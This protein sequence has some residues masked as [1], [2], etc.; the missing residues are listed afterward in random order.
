[1][2]ILTLCD[3]SSNRPETLASRICTWWVACLHGVKYFTHECDRSVI[4]RLGRIHRHTAPLELLRNCVPPSTAGIQHHWNYSGTVFLRPQP[5][6]STIGTTP[7]LCSSVDSRHTAPLELLR[8]C[9]PPSTAG[10]QH[11]WNYSGTVF[12]RPQ[13]AYSTIGTTPELCSSVHSRHTAPLKLLRN[14]VPP[15]T[16]GI[17]HHWNYS[18]TVFLRPQLAYSTIGTTPELC[19]SVH[20]RHT[21]PLEL[22]RNCV[23]PSTAGIQH[24]WNYSGTVFLRPQPAYSTIGT[25]PE[26]C[27]S[28]HSRHTAPLE[29][30]R[31]CV[32]PSTAGIQHHC[33]Y[34]GTVFLRPQPAYS[35]IGTTPELCSSVH[36][37]HTAPLELLRNCVPPSA[38]GIQHHWNYSGTVF[39]RPQPAYSTIGTTPEL[40]S[41]I[42]NRH[43]APLELLRNCVPPSTAGIQHHWNYSGTVFL[44]PQPAYST[45][46][47][48]PELCSSVHSRHTAPLELL[49]NC[50]PPSA[51]GIQHHWNYSGTVFLRPQPAYSTIGTT[52]ELCS[53]VHSRHAAPLELLRNCVPLSTTGSQ[54]RRRPI[55]LHTHMKIVTGRDYVVI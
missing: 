4:L 15:S 16:A 21:A 23:P 44:H 5:A 48:T 34:S 55:G 38:T 20:S 8:N 1:M 11:H 3:I 37:R 51:T 54:Q 50:V 43:T 14:C 52:P 9:V 41:S 40:C 17:Q 7:E 31:N 47:T 42:H 24:H 19:S 53:S 28:V 25:T 12:L 26:L 45:I 39:L 29:L 13:P 30:L 10:I 46:G 49:R 2:S 33:N 32:P 18:G 6:Y 35:T 36:S 22:L 27:S